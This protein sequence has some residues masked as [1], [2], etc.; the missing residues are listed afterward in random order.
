MIDEYKLLWQHLCDWCMQG[1][2]AK[3]TK[4]NYFLKFVY[5][6]VWKRYIT[7][8]NN[9]IFWICLQLLLAS[10]LAKESWA[11]LRRLKTI[12][13]MSKRWKE[14]SHRI[15]WRSGITIGLNQ[16]SSFGN[17]LLDLVMVD[18]YSKL[19]G[20]VRVGQRRL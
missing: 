20:L 19:S 4:Y 17:D 15:C 10:K 1:I 11:S 5:L 18:I 7:I 6:F 9:F 14:I 2:E 12:A 13:K 16:I 8:R 3:K